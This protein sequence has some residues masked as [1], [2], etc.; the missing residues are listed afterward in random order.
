MKKETK[1]ES[2][3]LKYSREFSMVLGLSLLGAAFVQFM[4]VLSASVGIL[5]SDYRVYNYIEETLGLNM[6]SI[7]CN[8]FFTLF[9]LG[10]LGAILTYLGSVLI[11]K[12]EEHKA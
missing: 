5:F 11:P 1:K 8:F 2:K 9:S 7:Y 6:P 12:F 3:G 4:V 10:S